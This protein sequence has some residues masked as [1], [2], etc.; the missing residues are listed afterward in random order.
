MTDNVDRR[1][2]EDFG[3]EWSR[4][5][6]GEEAAEDLKALF[7]LYFSDFPWQTLPNG[8]VG[9]DVG[10]GTGRWAR[11][12]AP[13]V[14]VLHCIEPSEKAL[15]VARQNLKKLPNCRFH[16]AAVDEIPL[17]ESSADFGYALGV[18]HHVP[19]PEEGLRRCVEKL[20]PGAPFLLYLY[21]AFDNRPGWYGMIWRV[22]EGLRKIISRMPRVLKMIVS[23]LIA[24]LVYYPLARVARLLEKTGLNV[25]YV[26]LSAY[27]NRSFYSM[28]T[29][30]LD[31]FGTRLE[32]RFTRDEV[33][34][35]MRK[36]GLRDIRF[37][38][39]GAFWTAVGF[40]A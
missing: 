31:R 14:G 19:D 7:D 28:R 1:V 25:S 5:S 13:R 2:V 22:S 35:I 30:A 27:R 26:P 34:A 37:N 38:L 18:L 36:A 29:D 12:V 32:H 24:L 16:R 3:N 10:C 9:F 21:Y 15:E 20:K 8:A 39:E 23:D 11:F 17:K 4:F 40:R 6:Q 33:A